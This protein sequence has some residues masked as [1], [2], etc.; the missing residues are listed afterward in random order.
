MTEAHKVQR[1]RGGQFKTLIVVDPLQKLLC[2]A[3]VPPHVELQSFDAVVANDEP[4]LQRT[5]AAAQRN[6]PVA[7]IENLARL[8]R[9]VPQVFRKNAEGIDERFAV[10]DIEAVAV[11][12]GEHPLM[13]V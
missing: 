2:E 10:G 13:R 7:I 9:L 1:R 5:K 11:E 3:D 4:Q 12:V 8:R 6:V